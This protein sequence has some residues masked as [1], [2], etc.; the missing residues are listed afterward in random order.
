MEAFEQAVQEVMETGTLSF[1]TRRALW[2]ALGPWEERDEMDN[3]PRTLSQPLRKRAELALACAKRV[4][5]VWAAYAPE[6]KGPQALVKQGNAY[7]GGK[8]AAEQLYQAWQASDYLHRTEEERYSYAPMAAIAAE[9][10]AAVPYYDEF[11]LEPQYAGA[12]DADLD[13]YDWDA[14]WCASL[15]WAHQDEEASPGEQ[16][17]AEQKFWA[18][19]LEQTA[20]LLGMEEW[21]FPKKAVRDFKNR[22][23]L[24]RPVPEEVTM[25]SFTAFLGCGLYQCHNSVSRGGINRFSKKL[26]TYDIHTLCPDRE[27]VCPRCRNTST[28]LNFYYGVNVLEAELPG[29]EIS[30]RLLHTLPMYQCPNCPDSS[31]TPRTAQV[32]AKA[33]LKRYLA[34]PGRLQAFQEELERRAANVLD[35][36]GGY[37]SLNGATEHHHNILIPD[38]VQG[39]RWLD[40]EAKQ[41]PLDMGRL[42]RTSYL[43]GLTEERLEIDL[44]RFGPHVYFSGLTLAEFREAY[45]SQTEVLEDG[46]IQLTME[47]HW[48][49]CWLDGTGKL[50]RVVV[51]SRF[52]LEVDMTYSVTV[53]RFL[54]EE[55]HLSQ[56]QAKEALARYRENGLRQG[57]PGPFS[58]LTRAEA[59]ELCAKL[60]SRGIKCRIMSVPVGERGDTELR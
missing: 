27:A 18:W 46:S 14:A 43:T 1:P 22:Q 7:L 48:A 36:G 51:Q 40:P 3:S 35:I 34:G 28:L 13:P 16:K 59:L 2:L 20:R 58:G 37:L 33:A 17:V 41:V 30:I 60:R 53:A 5:R 21:K 25:E 44:S 9:R 45:P 15:A 49:R 11:L 38:G 6:D 24:A 31:F 56:V 39:L 4:G 8:L 23:E 32:N 29:T 55:F 50:E 54:M 26:P 19:Y 47:R 10:A 52:H 42:G 57:E 12:D